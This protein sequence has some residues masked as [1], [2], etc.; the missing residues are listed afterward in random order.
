MKAVVT[1]AGSGA[2]TATSRSCRMRRR[3]SSPAT[4]VLYRGHA[5]AAVAAINDHIA[6][7]AVEPDRGRVRSAAA[8]ARRA[9]G[10]APRRA[11]PARGAAH[12]AT[13]RRRARRRRTSSRRPSSTFGDIEKG[14]AECDVDRRARVPT[15]MVHQ[16]YIEPQACDRAR[17]TPTASSRSG[18]RTQG[19]FPAREARAADARPPDLEDQGDPDG[20]RRRLRR[21]DQRL[22]G[23]GRGAALAARPASPSRCAWTAPT[24]SKAPARRRGT[25]IKVKLGAT[26]DGKLRAAY[27]DMAY[28]AGAFPGSAAMY[29]TMV[30]L[31]RL[32]HRAREARRLRRGRQQAADAGLPR[33]RRAGRRLRDRAARRRAGREA[34]AS[35][36]SSCA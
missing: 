18:R 13:A 4:K 24:S 27:A 36:R 7:E 32:R 9:R 17:G 2:R 8:R 33:A 34:R 3:T 14:F 26:K 19:S 1:G 25:S 16:G 22:P 15:K 30:A 5:V 12:D 23:A 35:T 10:D 21:Q 29:A 11:D 31:R 28:E 20:D 6:Q